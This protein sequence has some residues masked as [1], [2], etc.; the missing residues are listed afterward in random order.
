MFYCLF[1]LYLS[2]VEKPWSIEFVFFSPHQKIKQENFRLNAPLAEFASVLYP[3]P[4]LPKTKSPTLN[5]CLDRLATHAQS[6]PLQPQALA[7]AHSLVHSIVCQALD[8]E[9]PLVSIVLSLDDH[10]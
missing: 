5:I 3:R 8:P 2:V 9:Y 7:A 1:T 10:G 6:P 4:L